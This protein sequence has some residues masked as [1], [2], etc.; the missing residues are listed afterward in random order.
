MQTLNTGPQTAAGLNEASIKEASQK[1]IQSY[2][3]QY[4]GWG[5][6]PK[7]PQPMSL[8]FLLQNASR[9]D[10]EALQVS[11]H[12]LVS[13]ARGGMYDVIGGGFARYSVD[14][15]WLVPHFE[16]MLYDNAQLAR[17]Y[18]HAYLITGED[19]YRQVCQQ[20]L[21][22]VLRELTDPQGGFYSSLDAD[23][24]GE[25]GKYYVWT[26]DEIK[27]AIDNEADFQVFA[28]AYGITRQGNFEGKNIL[29]RAAPDQEI[30]EKFGKKPEPSRIA[31]RSPPLR[32]CYMPVSPTLLA[33]ST[34]QTAAAIPTPVRAGAETP[35]PAPA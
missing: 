31:A 28:S 24:E 22:F 13:M 15:T 9:G 8:R 3:R 11:L 34:S 12:A 17:V 14:N 32:T 27:G 5:R 2:D 1:L 29:Q 26:Y 4:G 19:Y 35:A 23:S 10:K 20:T 16:K 25:E 6:A 33:A 30:G 7:F 18:L 21:D